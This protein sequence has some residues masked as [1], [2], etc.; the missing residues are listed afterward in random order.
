[1]GLGDGQVRLAVPASPEYL[2]LTRMM[3]AGVASR[4]GFDLDEVDDLRI[5]I[6]E[7]CFTLVG[8]RGR[9]GTISTSYE[10]VSG[11]LVVEGVALLTDPPA[12]PPR[13]S[14]LSARILES[15]VDECELGW[16]PLGPTFRL[17]K[18]RR[19]E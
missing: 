14:E 1:M 6:D 2:R 10:V 3:A 13:L 19:S 5:A 8:T 18:R 11:A 7:V 4:L 9:P 12:G 17:L 16:S 15:V